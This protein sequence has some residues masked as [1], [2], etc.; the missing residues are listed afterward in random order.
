MKFFFLIIIFPLFF[1]AAHEKEP[2]VW[3]PVAARLES[4]KIPNAA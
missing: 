2:H 3:T 1:R 4:P